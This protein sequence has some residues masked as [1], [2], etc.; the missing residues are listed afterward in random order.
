LLESMLTFD[1]LAVKQP[2]ADSRCNL[3]RVVHE[4]CAVIKPIAEAASVQFETDVDADIQSFPMDADD[5]HR[6]LTNLV[7]NAIRYSPKNGKVRLTVAQQNGHVELHVTDEG[8]GIAPKH[9]PHVTERF[10]RAD[11]SRTTGSGGHGV[12]LAI[13]A[14]TTARYGGELTLVNRKK[15]GLEVR[16]RMTA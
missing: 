9:L 12:G 15:G 1:Q 16:I 7:D 14:E 13:V 6:V 4:F 11:D 2:G 8:Q 5:L 10:Y 3:S